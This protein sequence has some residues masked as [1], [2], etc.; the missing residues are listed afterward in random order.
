MYLTLKL[1][2]QKQLTRDKGASNAVQKAMADMRLFLEDLD[3]AEEC[4][5]RAE[6]TSEATA[7]RVKMFKYW[8]EN[9]L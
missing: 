7:V 8:L 9:L 4:G 5:E 1:K 6:R 2:T 3:D